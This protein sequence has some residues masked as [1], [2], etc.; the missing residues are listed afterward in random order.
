MVR[1]SWLT[2]LYAMED[3]RDITNN[4]NKE[5]KNIKIATSIEYRICNVSHNSN[6]TTP[7]Q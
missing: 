6:R 2:E 1:L 5:I 4:T 7:Q 3:D